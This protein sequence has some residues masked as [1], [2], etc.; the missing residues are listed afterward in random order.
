MDWSLTYIE[1]VVE[2]SHI[3]RKRHINSLWYNWV[4]SFSKSILS[5]TSIRLLH[6][7]WLIK[8]F[9]R[10]QSLRRLSKLHFL[11]RLLDHKL[12]ILII[13][14]ICRYASYI[15]CWSYT[16][17]C[18]P[19]PPF[20]PARETDL[21]LDSWV[22]L[23]NMSRSCIRVSLRCL[24][25]VS[26]LEVIPI[27]IPAHWRG[28]WSWI[29]W[30]KL[31]EKSCLRRRVLESC[32]VHSSLG[33]GRQSRGRDCLSS[34]LALLGRGLVILIVFESWHCWNDFRSNHPVCRILTSSS[35]SSYLVWN[36]LR[37]YSS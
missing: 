36:V 30:F 20:V 18:S 35:F 37:V 21:G 28:N 10:L 9:L 33:V 26:L 31:R 13:R 5:T 12:Y 32:L 22:D 16:W 17:Y 8:H 29:W 7:N 2:S 24:A 6:L 15:L 1:R 11:F 14:I 27:G 25:I 34:Q 19:K 4:I 3:R 23:R